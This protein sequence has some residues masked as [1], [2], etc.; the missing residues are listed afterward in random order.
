MAEPVIFIPG[1][2]CDARL[3]LHQILQLS[4]SRAVTVMLPLQATV[5]EMSEAVLE[6][7][8]AKVALV[9]HGLGGDVAL[10]VFRRA[11]ERISRMALIASNPMAETP[12][13][14]AARE[15]RMVGARMGRIAQ[16]ALDEIPPG[17]LAPLETRD[18]TLALLQ[19]MAVG[20][21]AEAFLG[22]SRA[23]QRRPDQQKVMRRAMLPVLILAGRL[24]T[25][26]PLRRQD[27]LSA[28][29]PYGRL[30]II[31]DAGHLAPLEQPEAVTAALR[32]FLDAPSSVR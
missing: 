11:P 25:V 14:A 32:A 15:A 19:E 16:V 23:M 7:A 6:A 29:M 10:D 27:F 12:Q 18:A 22:Q 21:G 26:V 3:F 5:E 2:L 8:P 31:E 30:Q 13:L 24:D 20:L 1:M 9:G 4:Q 28:L 17:A